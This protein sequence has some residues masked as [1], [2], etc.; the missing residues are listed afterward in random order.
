MTAGRIRRGSARPSTTRTSISPSSRKAL[1]FGPKA[2]SRIPP[3]LALL[4]AERSPLSNAAH[5]RSSMS[6]ASRVDSCE[7]CARGA[8]SVAQRSDVLGGGTRLDRRKIGVDVGDFVLA[9]K[10]AAIARHVLSRVAYLLRERRI[11][12]QARREPWPGAPLATL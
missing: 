5:R 11:G 2:R 9:H 7:R 6:C 1:A 12:P 4:C 10:A 3:G 8:A